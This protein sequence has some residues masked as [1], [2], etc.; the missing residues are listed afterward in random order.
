MRLVVGLGNPGLL[1]KKTRH[2]IG[3]MVLDAYSKEKGIKL[4]TKKDFKG[5]V[6]VGK[7]YVLLKPSTY[8]NKSGEAVVAVKNFYKIDAKD[9]LVISDDFNI[10]F[11]KLRLREKGSA[12]GHNG[13]KSIIELT[14]SSEFNRLRIGLGA[15]EHNNI[16]FVLSSF[17][18]E[19]LKEIEKIFPKTNEII[20]EFIKGTAYDSIMNKFNVNESI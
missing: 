18:K 13:L 16:D 4:K 12:G 17:E 1:Y 6:F 20:D 10:P 14:G 2:N 9:I 15:P 3:F 19:D 11:L 8:M 5:E 7:D